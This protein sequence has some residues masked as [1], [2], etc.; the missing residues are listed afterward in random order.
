M[1]KKVFCPSCFKEVS[2][3][4]C[5]AEIIGRVKG[6]DYKFIG[7]LAKCQRCGSLITAHDLCGY[8]SDK[9]I[10]NIIKEYEERR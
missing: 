6:K 8:N 5:D 10:E 9:L 7:K 2:F 4:V 1:D 3:T